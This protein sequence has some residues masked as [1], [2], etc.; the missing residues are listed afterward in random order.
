[1]SVHTLAVLD[2]VVRRGTA[3]L[4]EAPAQA[5]E[6]VYVEDERAFVKRI[7]AFVQRQ[8]RKLLEQAAPMRKVDAAL[9]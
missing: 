8:A 4:E 1:M 6:P 7:A 9:L 5:R 3:A 2:G